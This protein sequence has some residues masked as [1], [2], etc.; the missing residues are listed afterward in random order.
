MTDRKETLAKVPDLYSKSDKKFQEGGEAT[1]K[2][3][4]S[5]KTETTAEPQE[6]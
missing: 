6:K 1:R 4:H 5:K 3:K 2:Q